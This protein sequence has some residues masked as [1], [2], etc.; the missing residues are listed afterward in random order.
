MRA[1]R[2]STN[3]IS[4]MPTGIIS[5]GSHI[6]DHVVGNDQI[7]EWAGVSEEWIHERTGIL[8]RRYASTGT[9]TSD[10]AVHAVRQIFSE[11]DGAAELIDALILATCTPDVPQPATAAIVQHKLGLRVM[12]AFDVNAVCSGFLYGMAVADGLRSASPDTEHVLVVGADMFSTIMDRTDRSTVSLFGDGAGAVLL[13]PVPEGYGLLAMRTISDGALHHL[14]GVPAGGTALPLDRA[15]LQS[16]Q[17]FLKMDGR[18][19]R[20]YVHTTLPKIVDQVLDDAGLDLGGIDRFIFHQANPRLLESFADMTGIDRK[21]MPLTA[22][23]LGNTA[24]ASIP[25]TLCAADRDR[26]LERGE[27][28]LLA[29]IGGG[30]NAAAALVRWY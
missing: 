7:A 19:I 28:L 1:A 20:Q 24:G 5:I 11:C 27:N 23:H 13:G 21:R 10:L 25:V 4:P 9:A 17:N 6:P 3:W 15:A 26:P 16:G 8:E 14:V 2:P 22:P 29:S 12:P 18:A 30:M